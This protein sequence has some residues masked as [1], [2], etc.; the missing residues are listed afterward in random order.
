ME[1][2]LKQRLIGAAV[3]VAVV[4]LVL[5]E[6]LSG[7]REV[8]TLEPTRDD[9]GV[10]L[11]AHEFALGDTPTAEEQAGAADELQP[12]PETVPPEAELQAGPDPQAPAQPP[13]QPQTPPSGIPAV[14]AQTPVAVAAAAPAATPPAAAAAVSPPAK[15]PATVPAAAPTKAAAAPPPADKPAPKAAPKP[16]AAANAAPA[17]KAPVTLSSWVVQIGSF[18]TRQKAEELVAKLQRKGFRA[19]TLPYTSGGRTLH[20]VRVGPEQSRKTA[21]EIAKRLEA[22]GYQPHVT[23]QE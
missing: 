22:D 14:P 8:V 17:A 19:F 4:V 12:D 13:A 10:P 21:D 15:T 1:R 20:R 2:P 23:P 18:G 7:R 5:P 11:R 3:L 6:L 9:S 16:A